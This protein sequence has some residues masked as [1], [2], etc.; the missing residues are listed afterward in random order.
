M[1][2]SYVSFRHLTLVRDGHERQMQR[3]ASVRPTAGVTEEYIKVL[4]ES[5]ASSRKWRKRK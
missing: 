3:R 5:Y 1:A 2:A 4:P